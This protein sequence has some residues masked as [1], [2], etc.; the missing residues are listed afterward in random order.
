MAFVGSHGGH[1][2][3]VGLGGITFSGPQKHNIDCKGLVGKQVLLVNGPRR[4]GNEAKEA[5]V[6]G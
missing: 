4:H 1:N 5:W 3:N 2:K 6:R